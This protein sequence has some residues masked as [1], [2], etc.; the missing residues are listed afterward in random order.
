MPVLTPCTASPETRASNDAPSP[1]ISSWINQ[2]T[3]LTVATSNP[4]ISQAYL[5]AVASQANP[6]QQRAVAGQQLRQQNQDQQQQ[7]QPAVLT[8]DMSD[9]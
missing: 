7:Q 4:D 9:L 8:S 2:S 3:N 6:D 5:A 1:L